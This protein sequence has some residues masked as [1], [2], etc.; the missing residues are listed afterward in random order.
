MTE[1]VQKGLDEKYCSECGEIIKAN[2]KL[3]RLKGAS[4]P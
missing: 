4:I 2:K 1:P 3:S